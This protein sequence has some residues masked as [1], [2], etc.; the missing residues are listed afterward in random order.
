MSSP[1]GSRPD[2]CWLEITLGVATAPL[3]LGLM[4]AQSAGKWLQD[5]KLSDQGWW[6]EQRLPPLD[7]Q[8]LRERQQRLAQQGEESV[9]SPDPA[10]EG[11]RSSSPESGSK[12]TLDD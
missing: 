4:A 1:S 7:A 6:S 3:M 11:T 10:E 9:A 8:A 2:I 5:L 12:V